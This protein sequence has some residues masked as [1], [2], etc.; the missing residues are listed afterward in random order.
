MPSPA[1]GVPGGEYSGD[2]DGELNDP[3]G[4]RVTRDGNV[5]VT[6]RVNDRVSVFSLAS[7][8]W[9]HHAAT[10]ADVRSRWGGGGAGGV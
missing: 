7:K 10:K 4:L 1:V 8:S 5:V 6:D 3:C 9:V 2:A